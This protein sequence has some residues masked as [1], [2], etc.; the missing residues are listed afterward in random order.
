M[1]KCTVTKYARSTPYE[2][3]ATGNNGHTHRRKYTQIDQLCKELEKENDV[4]IQRFLS[5]SCSICTEIILDTALAYDTPQPTPAHYYTMST[6]MSR[7][8]MNDFA[9]ICPRFAACARAF[10][11]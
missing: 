10:D 2:N 3:V 5:V 11:G 9:V 6:H 1:A 7:M 4:S 8:F